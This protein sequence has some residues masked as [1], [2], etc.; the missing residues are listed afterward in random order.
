MVKFLLVVSML[1]VAAFTQAAEDSVVPGGV[2]EF[3]DI[4]IRVKDYSMMSPEINAVVY[5]TPKRNLKIMR[6]DISMYGITTT[7]FPT[8]IHDKLNYRDIY[9]GET[10]SVNIPIFISSIKNNYINIGVMAIDRESQKTKVTHKY[11]IEEDSSKI[12]LISIK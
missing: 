2:K 9:K 7:I 11:K 4:S 5:I 1:M 12:K 10:V 3:V 6:A 8:I